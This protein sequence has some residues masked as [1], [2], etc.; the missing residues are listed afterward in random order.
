[1]A[2]DENSTVS[3]R[4]SCTCERTE[5]FNLIH[6]VEWTVEMLMVIG[7]IVYTLLTRPYLRRQLKD[8][9]LEATEVEDPLNVS[10][11][12]YFINQ[13]DPQQVQTT[14]DIIVVPWNNNDQELDS[15]MIKR[16][17][18]ERARV[19]LEVLAGPG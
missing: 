8:N 15:R 10:A 4:P 6:S 5:P 9:K 3:V 11:P 18:P 2:R 12:V 17:N 7:I 14:E 1:M 13:E 19:Y 16:S